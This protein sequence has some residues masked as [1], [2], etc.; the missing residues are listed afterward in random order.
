MFVKLLAFLFSNVFVSF[1][2]LV[3]NRSFNRKMRIEVPIS[4]IE[5]T[6]LRSSSSVIKSKLD[7][8]ER[9]CARA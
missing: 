7:M 2:V 9:I 5:R 1:N 3:C 6:E 8:L 4:A